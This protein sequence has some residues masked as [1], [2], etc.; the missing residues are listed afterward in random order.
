MDTAITPRLI[1]RP[2]SEA[3]A[4][5]YAAIRYHPEVA[6]WLPAAEGDPAENAKRTIA[7]FAECWA[8]DGHG[9]WGMFLKEGGEEGALIGHGGLRV[10]PEFDRQT[11]ILYALH[12]E[13]WGK[14]YAS[15]LG[16]VAL[17]YGFE[18]RGLDS[19][20][21]ITKPDNLASQAV[22]KRLG[23]SYRKRVTYKDIEAVWY[24]IDRAT[25]AGD[26]TD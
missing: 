16:R 3:D 5:N 18:R 4:A 9:P 8:N 19:I 7:Y 25:F 12:P 22:M 11:E 21:A 15:E 13:A 23:M 6:R 24:D 20:F 17:R 26:R 14:G 1:L 2:L 10:I